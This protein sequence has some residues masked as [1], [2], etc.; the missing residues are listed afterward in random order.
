MFD[1]C[2]PFLLLIGYYPL[3]SESILNWDVDLPDVC[4]FICGF[5]FCSLGY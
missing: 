4:V 5:L 1:L 3:R 2:Y